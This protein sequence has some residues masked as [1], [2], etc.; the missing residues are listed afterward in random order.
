MTAGAAP[1]A[2]VIAG[3]ENMGFEVTHV[4]GLTET[5]GP[6][7]VCAPQDG[8]AAL[9]IKD[10]AELL[11]RQGV[12]APLQ[13]Q[14]MVADP[15]TLEPVPKDGKTMGEIFMRG[16]LVMKGY[17][18]NPK[19]TQASFKGGWFHSGD[20]A[21]WDEDG[22]V[23]IKD[24]SKDIIISGGENISSLE[25]ESVLFKH[26]KI[27]EAAVVASSDEK[28]GEVPCA[29]V[30]LKPGQE[31]PVQELIAYCREELAGFKIPKKVVF[32]PIAKTSTGK[33]QKFLLRETAEQAGYALK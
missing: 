1:P 7:V 14:L 21:V 22:Y 12:R 9:S 6:C 8:W 18:K 27:L 26:P 13:D 33:V 30:S 4:Y 20:L 29:F 32:G 23:Q 31:L 2:A 24:R 10:R 28:W 15:E 16:N 17:L 3:M 11:A 5:Y 25:I 19:T